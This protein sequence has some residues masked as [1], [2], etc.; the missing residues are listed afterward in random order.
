MKKIILIVIVPL[1]LFACSKKISLLSIGQFVAQ[2]YRDTLFVDPFDTFFIVPFTTNHDAHNLIFDTGADFVCFQKD[3]IP[4]AQHI[5]LFD[6]N[7]NTKIVDIQYF[8][9]ANVGNREIKEVNAVEIEFPEVFKCFGNGIL[10][11]NIIRA[12][13]WLIESDKIIMSNK[14]FEIDSSL[15]LDIFYYGA[16]RLHSNFIFNGCA[17][18]TCLIDYGGLFDVELPTSAF[19]ELKSH[20]VI[21]SILNEKSISYGVHGKAIGCKRKINCNINFNGLEIDSVNIEVKD[22]SEKRVGIVF[23]KRF[24]QVAINNSNSK[25]EFGTLNKR[26]SRPSN[27]HLYSFDLVNHRF[28][29]AYIALNDSIVPELEIGDSFI[30]I[31]S[32]KSADFNSYCDFLVWKSSIEQSELLQLINDENELIKIK[33]RRQQ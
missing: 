22:N 4:S 27:K 13:N 7:G 11:N 32:K 18:D 21:N 30:E 17:I 1:L 2:D 20:I 9:S 3:S 29:V 5:N 28:I 15:S 8:E 23:M 33:N 16:N 6:S 14:T 25:L 26:Q 12:S 31:N 19:K 24:K 10:G